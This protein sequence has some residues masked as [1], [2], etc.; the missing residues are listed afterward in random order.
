MRKTCSYLV[1]AMLA[2]GSLVVGQGAD[3]NR[4]LA[5][6]RRALGGERKLA[7][8]RTIAA[9]GRSTRVNGETSLP[10]TDF[11]MAIEF[12]DKYMRKDVLATM[13]STTI[14]RTSGFNGDGLIETIDTPP[15][16]PGMVVFRGPGGPAGGP[17]GVATP[18]QMAAAR[19][20]SLAATRQDF[21][22]LALGMFAASFDVYPLQFSDA[23]RAE[24]P[25][26]K[27]D[28]IGVQGPDDFAMRLF[29]DA[30]SHLPLMLSWMGKEPLQL[31]QNGRGAAAGSGMTVME[32]GGARAQM[33]QE[34]RDRMMKDMEAR[35]KEADSRRRLVEYRL[36]YG[37]YQDVSGVKIPMRLQRSIDGK[38]VE[39]VT[40]EK[41]KV[42]GKIDPK[43]FEVTEGSAR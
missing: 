32:G 16:M 23:G 39:E 27:A 3:V 29:T 20:A 11:E 28:V 35:M 6:V 5:D 24:S 43:K 18:E 14:S 8:V 4:V 38:P 37:D 42:N 33:T 30:D 41:V 13:G 26:G 12:P 40:L 22:Q 25:D 21:A 17:G 9:T 10:S 1:L 15:S 34:E 19:K 31:T 7:A 36:Y 2:S